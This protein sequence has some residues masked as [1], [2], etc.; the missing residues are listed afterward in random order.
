MAA[1]ALTLA[2]IFVMVMLLFIFAGLYGPV[3]PTI[4][5][6]I[7]GVG[8]I[9]VIL[10]LPVLLLC[11]GAKSLLRRKPWQTGIFSILLYSSLFFLLGTGR[12]PNGI[13]VTSALAILSG[14]LLVVRWRYVFIQRQD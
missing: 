7:I 10:L 8:L 12:L 2:I 11:W 6:T 14:I 9:C 5:A 13:V 1:Y 3:V 4:G